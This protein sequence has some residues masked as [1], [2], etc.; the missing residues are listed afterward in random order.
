[1]EGLR[2]TYYLKMAAKP[3]QVLWF[4]PSWFTVVKVDATIYPGGIGDS[5]EL[6]IGSSYC[7]WN[8]S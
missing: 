5:D 6:E 3:G 4:D 2:E 1:M 8:L 7:H